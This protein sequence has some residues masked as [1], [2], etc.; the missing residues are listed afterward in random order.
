[1]IGSH[2]LPVEILFRGI[3]SSFYGY[4]KTVLDWPLHRINDRRL[5]SCS[6]GRRHPVLFRHL[7][8]TR[9]RPPGHLGRLPYRTVVVGLLLQ[10]EN[11]HRVPARHSDILTPVHH[12]G[13]GTVGDLPSELSLPEKLAVASV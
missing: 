7:S 3:H 13:D 10:R 2:L 9:R 4:K 6:L 8:F 12:V 11:E 1:M 5:P